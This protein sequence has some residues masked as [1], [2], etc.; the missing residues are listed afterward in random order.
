MIYFAAAD[1]EILCVSYAVVVQRDGFSVPRNGDSA[2]S[3]QSP[4][5]P[6]SL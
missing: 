6:G 2:C 5:T 1:D 3:A 4:V